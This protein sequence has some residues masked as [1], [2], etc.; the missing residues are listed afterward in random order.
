MGWAV[1]GSAK[2]YHEL[3]ILRK[4]KFLEV[5]RMDLVGR[6]KATTIMKTKEV[7][8]EARGGILFVDE[9]FTLGM[10]GKRNRSDF[11]S[12]AVHEII[13]SI[14]ESAKKRGEDNHPLIILAGFPVEM[15]T[16][17][18]FNTELRRRFPL[19]FGFPDYSCLELA[20]IFVDLANA[21]GFDL[22]NDLKPGTIAQFLEE[23]TSSLWRGERNGRISEM[24]LTGCRSEVR[25]RMR[26]AQMEDDMDFDPQLIVRSDVENVIRSDFK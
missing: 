16:F 7:I 20:Q 1:R 15:N 6:D 10:A 19:T 25:K 3:G 23:E 4:P 26:S 14:D 22:S 5:E 8:D 12:V 11:A 9:A 17:L 18:V 13:N 24:L 2:A 21:K